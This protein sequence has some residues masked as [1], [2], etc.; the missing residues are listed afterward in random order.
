MPVQCSAVA[1]SKGDMVFHVSGN[2][3]AAK[4]A[5]LSPVNNNFKLATSGIRNVVIL[6]KGSGYVSK[7]YHQLTDPTL[8]REDE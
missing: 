4:Q 1:G 6:K 8:V 2:T 3:V 7:I 5:I